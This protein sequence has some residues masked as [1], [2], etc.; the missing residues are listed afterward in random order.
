MV[1]GQAHEGLWNPVHCAHGK[2]AAALHTIHQRANLVLKMYIR[3]LQDSACL[4]SDDVT[5][6]LSNR[7][8]ATRALTTT[9]VTPR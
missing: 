9:R 8:G 1:Q 5:M 3:T 4:F 2:Q 6:K 7:N